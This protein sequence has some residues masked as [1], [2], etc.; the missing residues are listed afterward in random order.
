MAESLIL[1]GSDVGKSSTTKYTKH[2]KKFYI[3][4]SLMLFKELSLMFIV[5]WDVDFWRQFIRNVW[6]R[7][8]LREVYLFVLNR[9]CI[10]I[11]KMSF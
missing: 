11:I 7:N 9:S 3:E 8:F 1:N 4:Q 2:T 10:C 6:K 5:K